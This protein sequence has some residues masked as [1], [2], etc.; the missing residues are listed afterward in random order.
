MFYKRRSANCLCERVLNSFLCKIKNMIFIG[1]HNKIKEINEMNLGIE[2][3]KE[4]HFLSIVLF[5][6]L[7]LIVFLK[8]MEMSHLKFTDSKIIARAW[9]ET[10][11]RPGKWEMIFSTGRAG[12]A[13]ERW[14]FEQA[15][16]PKREMSFLTARSGYKKWKTNNITSQCGPAK[17]WKSFE[18]DG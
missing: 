14:F 11:T 13:H 2:A 18:T 15:G 3:R 7:L 5:R 4:T 12:P 10:R 16:P 9:P 1:R 6:K 8:W 17:Q